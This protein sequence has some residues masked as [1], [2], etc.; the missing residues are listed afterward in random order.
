MSKAVK[1]AGKDSAKLLS[2]QKLGQSGTAGRTVERV[3]VVV[4][5]EDAKAVERAGKYSAKPLS[6]Q[7]L[8]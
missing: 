2:A 1:C 4:S 8:G 7:K 5:V 3:C 6:A